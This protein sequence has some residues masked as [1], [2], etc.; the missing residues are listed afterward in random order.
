MPAGLA[1]VD[2]WH[3]HSRNTDRGILAFDP[4]HG[5]LEA[6]NYPAASGND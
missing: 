6:G 5:F 2:S 4:V 1:D 3:F